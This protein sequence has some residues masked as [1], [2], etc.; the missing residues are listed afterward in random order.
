MG[1]ITHLL[2]DNESEYIQIGVKNGLLIVKT[3]QTILKASLID[4]D[5]PDYKRVIPAEKGTVIRIERDKLLHAVRRMCVVSS[6]KYNG[7]IMTASHK[8][9][10]FN[11]KWICCRFQS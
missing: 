10:S 8:K 7:M 2:D 3:D 4:G 9:L 11:S 1:E 5:Y 6:E